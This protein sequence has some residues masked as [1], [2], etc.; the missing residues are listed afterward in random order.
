MNDNSLDSE[1][2][3]IAKL[4]HALVGGQVKRNEEFRQ[5]QAKQAERE[6]KRDMEQAKRDKEQAKR[7]EEFRR[8]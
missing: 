4:L 7:D 2:Q 8:W 1:G 3:L 5:W 6:E